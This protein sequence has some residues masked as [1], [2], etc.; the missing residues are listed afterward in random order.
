MQGN[1]IFMEKAIA[2]ATENFVFGRS[3]RFEAAIVRGGKIVAI[4]P[5]DSNDKPF[6]GAG[7]L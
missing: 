7:K 5:T 1:P 6:A 2:L 4:G 3:E